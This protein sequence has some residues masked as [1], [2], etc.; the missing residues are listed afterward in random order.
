M[1]HMGSTTLNLVLQGRHNRVYRPIFTPLLSPRPAPW[2]LLCESGQTTSAPMLVD[3]W[4]DGEEDERV[5]VSVHESG[6][7]PR[8]GISSSLVEFPSS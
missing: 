7:K 5:D 4:D 6:I 1:A 8:L 3:T 2:A